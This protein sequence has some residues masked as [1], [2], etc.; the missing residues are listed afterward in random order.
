MLTGKRERWLTK[1]LIAGGVLPEVLNKGNAA[2]QNYQC[3]HEK[4]KYINYTRVNDG[5]QRIS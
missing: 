4:P 5:S 1:K 3:H 2:L